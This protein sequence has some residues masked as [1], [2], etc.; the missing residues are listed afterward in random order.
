[1]TDAQLQSGNNL[2]G[3]ARCA[4][5][6]CDPGMKIALTRQI[7][8]DWRSGVLSTQSMQPV[9]RIKVPGRPAK[10]ELLHPSRVAKRSFD[11]VQGRICLAHAIAH[12]EFNAINLALDAVY[13]FGDMPARYYT[14]WLR[15]AVEESRHFQL[16]CGYLHSQ[17]SAYGEYAAHN[18]LWEMAVKTDHD[19][20]VRMA[21]VPRV[22]EA[23]GLDVTPTMIKRL[24]R[25]GD[26]ALIEIL[27]IIFEEEI[28]HVKIGSHW[29]YHC[30]EQRSIEPTDTFIDLLREY[31]KNG[32]SGPFEMDARVAAGFSE[33]EM[34]RIVH[35]AQN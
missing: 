7:A 16:L 31:F 18:G 34:Q 5:M 28:G 13:R 25:S 2:H 23:R 35:L 21:L 11:S 10:P 6:Q 20:M 9:S 12:I 15:V 17:G 29:F 27:K 30:C 14:D 3:Q 32:L 8:E 22:L 26:T 19:V 1:M 33:Y 24:E 4:L